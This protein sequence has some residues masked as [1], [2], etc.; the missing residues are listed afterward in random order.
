[1]SIEI[2]NHIYSVK[3]GVPIAFP[4]SSVTIGGGGTAN[5]EGA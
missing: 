1:M 5:G 2:F 4:V 3:H